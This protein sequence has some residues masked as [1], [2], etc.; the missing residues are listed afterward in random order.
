MTSVNGAF[1]ILDR[2]PGGEEAFVSPRGE[3]DANEHSC[4]G[5]SAFAHPAS[6]EK[7]GLFN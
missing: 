1:S 6:L 2:W 5:L 4:I 3:W 7:G